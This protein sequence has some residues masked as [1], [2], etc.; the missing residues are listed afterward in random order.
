MDQGL[1]SEQMVAYLEERAKGDVGL[2]VIGSTVPEAGFDWLENASDAII[3]RYKAL[4]DAGHRHGMAV[5]APAC[6]SRLRPFL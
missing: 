3:P 6:S 2:F 1:P 4:A 5:F